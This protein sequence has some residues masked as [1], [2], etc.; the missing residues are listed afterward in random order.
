MATTSKRRT[1][2]S[3]PL[4]AVIL[5]HADVEGEYVITRFVPLSFALSHLDTMLWGENAKRHD[6][7]GV[8]ESI[9]TYGFVDHPKW[10]GNLNG[11]NGGIVYGNNRMAVIVQALSIA[12]NEGKPAPRGIPTSKTDGEWCI[13]I[14]WGVDA[15]SEAQ[16]KALGVDHNTLTLSGADLGLWDVS[17]IWNLDQYIDLLSSI[18]EEGVSPVTVDDDALASLIFMNENGGP[19]PEENPNPKERDGFGGGEPKMMRCP[20]CDHE[21]D[22]G[23]GR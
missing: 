16:A 6:F 5:S 15:K 23:G 14:G 13:P 12:K 10:D 9:C 18:A 20:K 21:W 3:E 1:Q 2:S 7:G 11:G 22:L 4:S 19:P 17:K 8:Y